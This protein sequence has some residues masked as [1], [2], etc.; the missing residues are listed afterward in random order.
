MPGATLAIASI[1]MRRVAD[2]A[3]DR[4]VAARVIAAELVLAH[5]TG[6]RMDLS[7]L[8]ADRVA[9]VA[10]C[11]AEQVAAA[12]QRSLDGDATAATAAAIRRAARAYEDLAALREPPPDHVPTAWCGPDLPE[13][14]MHTLTVSLAYDPPQPSCVECA[15]SPGPRPPWLLTDARRVVCLPCVA[16]AGR[17]DVASAVELAREEIAAAPD[18]ATRDR[19]CRRLIY[20]D[21]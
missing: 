5:H 6:Q 8:D 11:L 15:G 21:G 4:W 13:L 19:I 20:G 14:P 2:A 18:D 16:A 10:R 1:V 12:D 9:D 7:D 3:L 17:P